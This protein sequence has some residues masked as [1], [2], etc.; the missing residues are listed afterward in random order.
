MFSTA[1]EQA[2]FKRRITGSPPDD[3]FVYKT[4]RYAITMVSEGEEN[5]AYYYYPVC[6][7][8]TEME[9]EWTDILENSTSNKQIIEKLIQFANHHNSNVMSLKSLCISKL[10]SLRKSVFTE[11]LKPIFSLMN[12][13]Q[14][15]LLDG[16]LITPGPDVNSYIFRKCEKIN[17]Q[18]MASEKNYLFGIDFVYPSG[19]GGAMTICLTKNSLYVIFKC[20][21]NSLSR[22]IIDA[23][24]MDEFKMFLGKLNSSVRNLILDYLNKPCK[25]RMNVKTLMVF[26]HDLIALKKYNILVD[27][28]YRKIKFTT[29]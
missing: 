15:V 16:P 12:S 29:L 19:L 11:N 3:Y 28:D 1:L 24:S 21:N 2:G 4:D 18:I 20:N 8:V 10:L 6:T 26:A 25:I 5:Y 17:I 23:I 7:F 13:K 9:K 22:F 27:I 14:F